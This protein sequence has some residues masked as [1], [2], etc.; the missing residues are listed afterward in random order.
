MT[1]SQMRVELSKAYSTRTW[2]EKVKKMPDYQVQAIYFRLKNK[3]VL[4]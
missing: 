1:T 4:R 3:G 2:R